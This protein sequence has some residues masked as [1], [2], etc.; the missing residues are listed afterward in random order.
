[1]IY[2]GNLLY[3]RH[4]LTLHIFEKIVRLFKCFTNRSYFQVPFDERALCR[5]FLF[6]ANSNYEGYMGPPSLWPSSA[7]Q[8]YQALITRLLE[9]DVNQRLS[10]KEFYCW[11]AHQKILV[12][13]TAVE[14]VMKHS[15]V[16]SNPKRRIYRL[17]GSNGCCAM[18]NAAGERSHETEM[19][20]TNNN[21]EKQA[22]GNCKK[23]NGYVTKSGPHH[24]SGMTTRVGLTRGVPT[25]AFSYALERC[26]WF[27]GM[28][29]ACNYC[30][31]SLRQYGYDN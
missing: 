23:C 13:E 5:L 20:E 29:V 28:F 14:E 8:S 30:C 2:D 19:T 3:K 17:R 27:S 31:F 18:V 15:D 12:D 24:A 1:M 10:P 7:S 26:I 6:A 21:D 11:I 22:N 4:R 9:L 16:I 25:W